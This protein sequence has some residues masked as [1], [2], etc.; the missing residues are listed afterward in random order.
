MTNG[1]TVFIRYDRD[2]WSP[3]ES[4]YRTAS[5][6]KP[7]EI[8]VWERKAYRVVEVREKAHA[9]WPERYRDEWVKAG[10]PDPTGWYYRPLVVVLQNESDPTADALHLI[11][12]GNRTW[13]T[14]PEHYSICHR[15]HEIPPCTHVHTE[16]VMERANEHMAEQMAI[17]PGFCHACNEPITHRQKSTVFSGPNLIRPDFGDDSA[18]FHLRGSCYGDVESYDKRW[19]AATGSKRRFFCNGHMAVHIDKSL[20]CTEGAECPGD[21]QHQS[22]EWH[23]PEHR[24]RPGLGI[25]CWCLAGD[26]AP[27]VETPARDSLF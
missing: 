14:L 15:C 22:R 26:P 1:A 16:G 7:G 9:N 2:A 12:P 3:K 20:T 18:V 4:G 17:M 21:V 13:Y 27:R 19:A 24:D 25:T 6:L 8:T 5:S 11:G 23:H 10:M